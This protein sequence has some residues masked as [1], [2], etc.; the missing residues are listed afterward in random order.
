[1]ASNNKKKRHQGRRLSHQIN[2]LKAYIS[3]LKRAYSMQKGLLQLSE[4]ASQVDDL[5]QFYPA[6]HKYVK[7]TFQAENFY[8]VL[9]NHLSLELET[10]Y[11]SDQQDSQELPKVKGLESG[12]TGYVF[13]SGETLYCDLERF[14]ALVDAGSI[15]VLGTPS[16]L[17]IGVPLK[18]DGRTIGVMAIQ[19]YNKEFSITPQQVDLFEQIGLHLMTAIERVSRREGLER[20]VTLRTHQLRQE[21]QHRKHAEKLQESFYKI[22]ELSNSTLDMKA[23]YTQLHQIISELMYAENCYIALIDDWDY[24]TFPFYVD[25][26]Q[27]VSKDRQ[28]SKGLTEYVISSKSPQLIDTDRAN[29]L[30]SRGEISRRANDSEP[31]TCWLGAPLLDEEEVIGVLTVQAYDDEHTYFQSDLQLLTFVSHH[32]ASAISRKKA[33]N[34]LKLS[35]AQLELKV[36]ERTADLQKAN[37]SLKTEIEQRKQVEEKLYYQAN[38]DLLTDLPNRAMFRAKLEHCLQH[39][40]RHSQHKYA[41]LFIDLDNFKS[42]NDKFGHQVGDE[43]LVEASKR[44]VGCVRENDIVARFGGDE[45]VILLDALVSVDLIEEIAKRILMKMS[46]PFALNDQQVSSGASIGIRDFSRANLEVDELLKQAD[47]AM[48]RA[49]QTGRGRFVFSSELSQSL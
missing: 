17:Y 30:V 8:V 10:V 46:E 35:H 49:K 36:A 48:Y 29:E 20:E 13:R 14:Q 32:I 34:A 45:F 42:I 28:L 27:P 4:L 9:Q 19:F 41:L 43:F 38:H 26:K 2:R 31:A 15:L 3:Q 33:A 22:S 16:Q 18:S 24:L 6:L 11:F 1:M 40:S 7:E 23:F 5:K 47:D 37:A 44:I 39:Q 21:V 25:K 12:L